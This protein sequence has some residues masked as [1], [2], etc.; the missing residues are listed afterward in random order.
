MAIS[1]SCECGKTFRVP[2]EQTGKKA[3]CVSCNQTILIPNS[4]EIQKLQNTKAE[5]EKETY[6][7]TERKSNKRIIPKKKSIYKKYRKTKSV[8]NLFFIL[9]GS[10]GLFIFLITVILKQ[11]WSEN[12]SIRQIM[13]EWKELPKKVATP[14]QTA[15]FQK[16]KQ[17]REVV[18][19]FFSLANKAK[20]SEA[21]ELLSEGSKN[22]LKSAFLQIIL[23]GIKGY[24]NERTENGTLVKLDILKE[25]VRGEGATVLVK[26][27]F[28]DGSTIS[29]CKI[30]LVKENGVWK[31]SIEMDL[32]QR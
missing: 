31:I 25:Y 16:Q 13:K 9:I 26:L 8:E 32:E 24:C 28:K 30:P 17:P 2:D 29:N 10:L 22:F 20:Y 5:Q 21:E 4:A 18:N 12:S 19:T 11:D 3:K 6:S 23:G 14:F 15:L 27:T 1:F 7:I